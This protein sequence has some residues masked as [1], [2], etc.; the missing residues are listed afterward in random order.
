MSIEMT[1]IMQYFMRDLIA[2]AVYFDTDTLGIT[3]S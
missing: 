1:E 2:P 3:N